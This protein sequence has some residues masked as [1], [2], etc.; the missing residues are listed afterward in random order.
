MR[1]HVNHV[2]SVSRIVFLLITIIM[3]HSVASQTPSTTAP[4]VRNLL[5][6][7]WNLNPLK[8]RFLPGPA[9]RSEKRT[10]ASVPN[11]IKVK[12]RTVLADGHIIDSET[13]ADYDGA[14]HMVTGNPDADAIRLKKINEY[15]AETTVKHAG[16]IVATARREISE[17]GKTMTISYKGTRNGEEVNDTAVFEKEQ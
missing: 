12:I 8:S 11:G 14:E 5:L 6:G 4:P 15:I 17:D 2:Q 3:A 9:P 13:V 1:N 16:E 7:T 10:Y